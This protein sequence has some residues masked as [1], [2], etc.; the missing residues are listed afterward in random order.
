MEYL[1]YIRTDERAAVGADIQ[2]FVKNFQD[3]Q[4]LESKQ[5]E[6][7]RAQ[8]RKKLERARA[9]LQAL[10]ALEGVDNDTN[11]LLRQGGGEKVLAI[12]V[13]RLATID[14][15][16]KPHG[17]ESQRAL[18]SYLA[19][20]YD[21]YAIN[22]GDKSERRQFLAEVCCAHNIDIPDPQSYPDRLEEMIYDVFELPLEIHQKA[23]QQAR[24]KQK[25]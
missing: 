5:P 21:G 18:V 10:M 11:T 9:A 4:E 15:G 19:A 2:T 17:H 3:S 14:A 24:D 22:A 6:S 20:L 13:D 12:I 23:A 16:R 1:K 25:K 8:T 7:L